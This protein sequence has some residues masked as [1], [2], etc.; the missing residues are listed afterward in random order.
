M[1]LTNSKILVEQLALPKAKLFDT[2]SNAYINIG[3]FDDLTVIAVICNHCPFVLHIKSQMQT[4]FNELAAQGILVY[5]ISGNDPVQYPKDGPDLMHEFAKEFT[6]PYLYDQQ[7]TYLKALQ[8]MCTPE[9]YVFK[10][11]QLFYHGRFDDS[12]PS[13]Q[14]PVT[15]FELAMAITAAQ[16]NIILE[17]QFPSQGCSIKWR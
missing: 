15:G 10:Q 4:M 5:A 16:N 17:S 6:F 14:K 8:A 12:T 2:T 13:N 1:A 9:F 3:A 11:K 7:Q